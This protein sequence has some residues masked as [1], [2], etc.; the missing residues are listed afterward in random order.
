MRY[1]ILTL[2]LLASTLTVHGEDD[3]LLIELPFGTLPYGVGANGSTVVGSYRLP[4]NGFYWMP[5]TGDIFIGGGVGTFAVSRDGHTIVGAALDSRRVE[6]AAI[7]QRGTEWRLL[8]S[9]RPNAVP[10]DDLLSTGRGTSA[11][12]KVIVGLA[13]D[14]CGVARAFRWEEATGMVDL[15]TIVPNRSTSANGV[16]ADGSVVVGYQQRS[17]GVRQGARWV[18]GKEEV[19]TNPRGGHV[20]DAFG[21]NGDGSIVVGQ[22]CLPPDVGPIDQSAWIWTAAEGVVCLPVPGRRLSAE[23]LATSTSDDG[24][25]IGGGHGEGLDSEAVLWIDRQPTY[26]KDYLR[27]HGVPRAFDGWINT[28][29]INGVSPDGRVLVGFG[30]GRRDFQGFVVILG[31]RRD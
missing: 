14:S 23:G 28:G 15:G 4:A 11:D 8:G 12:G 31:S 24:R 5:T 27:A 16:S 1:A 21:T 7:W 2:V 9:I 30:A 18:D 19:F 20:G 6:Q 29:F 25:V 13:W 17:D 3:A 26:L 10:C 22:N